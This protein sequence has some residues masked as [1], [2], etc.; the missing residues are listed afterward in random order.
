MANYNESLGIIIKNLRTK[1]GLTQKNLAEG[2]CSKEYIYLLEKGKRIPSAYILELL[3]LKLNE[4]LTSYLMNTKD[5]V[6][7]KNCYSKINTLREKK[8]YE[9]LQ[10][11]LSSI[12][13]LNDF[14]D[15]IHKQFLLWNKGICSYALEKNY[16]KSLSLL[17]KALSITRTY[18]TMQELLDHFLTKQE[19]HIINSISN[20]Y[21]KNKDIHSAITINKR[22]IKNITSYYDD[23]LTDHLYSIALYNLAKYLISDLAYAQALNTIEILITFCTDNNSLY[24][25]GEAL[26]HKGIILYGLEK[27]VQSKQ[28]I[29]SA[30][31]LFN[32]TGKLS[33]L[34]LIHSAIKDTYSKIGYI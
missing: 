8:D 1:K 17:E 5:P 12:E 20:L 11:L 9:E 16:S 21:F 34:N 15:S 13:Q 19:L 22:I 24:L 31:N 28:S 25:L 29:E 2:I 32:I 3:S 6:L 18:N 14:Q 27:Y 7:V 30:Q 26:Y 4:N 10:R 23:L 33:S